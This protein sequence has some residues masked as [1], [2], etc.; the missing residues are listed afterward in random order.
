MDQWGLD[1]LCRT[2]NPSLLSSFALFLKIPPAEKEENV[3]AGQSSAQVKPLQCLRPVI[4]FV[5]GLGFGL[6][7]TF[8]LYSVFP[9]FKFILLIFGSTFPSLKLIYCFLV[10]LSAEILVLYKES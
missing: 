2:P 3:N 4:G 8:S 1:E 6:Q 10:R 5:F 9:L 7:V